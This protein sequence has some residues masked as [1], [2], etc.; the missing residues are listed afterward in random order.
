[1]VALATLHWVQLSSAVRVVHPAALWCML[2]EE[3]LQL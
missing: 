3:Q 2:S 1:M